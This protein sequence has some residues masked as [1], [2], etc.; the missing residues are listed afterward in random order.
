MTDQFHIEFGESF[1]EKYILPKDLRLK[2][3][4]V[5][6]WRDNKV[7]PYFFET[8]QKHGRMNIP[9]AIWIMIIKELN[10]IGVSTEKLKILS[11]KVWDVPKENK[12]ADQVILKNI[13][14]KKSGLSEIGKMNLKSLLSNEMVM[15]TLREEINHFTDTLKSCIANI[16]QP[17]YIIYSPLTDEHVFLSNNN[18]QFL[19]LSSLTFKY[20]IIS[21]PIL[22]KLSKIIS[23]DLNIKNKNLKYLSSI[24]N[25]IREIVLFK[26]PK[27][28]EIA[29]DNGRIKPKTITEKHVRQE[30]LSDF[31]IRN[32]IPKGSKL[33]IDPR[34]QD[35]YK[36]TLI[37]K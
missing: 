21:I 7:I 16:S 2:S 18:Y 8:H 25:Q 22:D 33:L 17:H 5:S 36:L 20:P 27:V 11:Y 23:I 34:S 19:K 9:E 32:K 12:Y 28:V 3:R 37:T 14:S 1:Y 13:N 35:N 31:F 15:D 4:Q 26:K 24:E 10:D 30:E 29:F 6:Y